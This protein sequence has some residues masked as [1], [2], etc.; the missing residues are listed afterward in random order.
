[1]SNYWVVIGLS[2]IVVIGL[3]LWVIRDKLKVDNLKGDFLDVTLGFKRALESEA[4]KKK[5]LAE[6]RALNIANGA[7]RD[8]NVKLKNQ[9]PENLAKYLN[10]LNRGSN[11][12]N[13]DN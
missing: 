2:C 11:T 10:A 4:E 12:G 8:A 7:I 9:P 1:M 5:A 6:A 3:M 13:R